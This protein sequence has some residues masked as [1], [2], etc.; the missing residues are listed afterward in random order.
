MTR[1]EK[2]IVAILLVFLITFLFWTDIL[3]VNL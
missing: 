1:G 2:W 3:N